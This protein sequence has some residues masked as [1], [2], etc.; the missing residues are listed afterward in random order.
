M[1]AP[2]LGDEETGASRRSLLIYDRENDLFVSASDLGADAALAASEYRDTEQRYEG[3]PEIDIVLVG[4]D[5]LESVKK[6][7]S[8]Y[9]HGVA[10][11]DLDALVASLGGAAS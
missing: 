6:T 5:S 2:H 11:R 9:F 4:S 8:T 3:H 10:L 1:S 7:H